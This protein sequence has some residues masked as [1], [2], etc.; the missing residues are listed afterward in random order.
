MIDPTK[1]DTTCHYGLG[2]QDMSKCRMI[3]IHPAI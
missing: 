2:L 1:Q 3:Y